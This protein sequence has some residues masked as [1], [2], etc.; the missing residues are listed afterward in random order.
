MDELIHDLYHDQRQ[1][2]IATNKREVPTRKIT[3]YLGWQQMMT[4]VYSLDSFIGLASK[5]ELLA[6]I[7]YKYKL[8]PKHTVYVGDTDSDYQ[9][10]VANDLHYIMVQWGY[11]QCDD[12]KVPRANNAQQLAVLLNQP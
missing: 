3:E 9:A 7:M 2:F 10:A 11:G 6:E 5:K 4:G 12:A 8:D 1:L